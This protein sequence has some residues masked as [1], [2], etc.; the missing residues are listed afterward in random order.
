MSTVEPPQLPFAR[1]DVLHLPPE[2]LAL[3]AEAPIVPVRTPA[4]DVAWLVT[5]YAETK[6]LFA[7]PRLGRS[8]PD[9]ERAARISASAFLGGPM[10]ETGT[11]AET[12]ARLRRLLAPA[13]SA[14]RMSRLR[15][16]VADLVAGLLDR[17]E[18]QGAPADLHEALSFPLPVL[19]ICDLLGVPFEDREQFRV[20][21]QEASNLTDR[22]AATAAAGA[23]V[24]YMAGLIDRKR[25]TPGE[26]LLSDLLVA[27]D[28]GLGRDQV[29][30]IAA[31]LLFAGHE[32]TVARIDLGALL[33]MANPDQRDRLRDDP[34]AVPR[35]VEEI[36]RVAAPAGVGVP[37]YARTDIDVG[38][39][40]IRAGDAVV[41]TGTSANR[42][43]AAFPDP[44]RFDIGRD[45]NPHLSFGYGVHYCI[46]AG[47]ARVELQEVFAALPAR[48]PS[49]RPAVPVGSLRIRDTL[50]GGVS[51]LPV[52]W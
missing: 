24:G 32:T 4:G 28:G 48:F 34:E 9:P 50:T 7:D 40:T 8:H 16:H 22:T 17:L 44:D 38:G 27:E 47:L 1:Q 31:A 41:L 52:T 13:F 11:E 14:R 19:V 10:G 46:G 12:Q 42:D 21:S 51:S 23:L 29:A 15:G 5:R 43:P 45:P 37:R 49:M 25:H 2:F 39:V 18:D 3:Q 26:D 36:L 30:F 20:W 35:A 6:A 33:L